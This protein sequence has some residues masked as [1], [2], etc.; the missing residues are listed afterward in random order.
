[1]VALFRTT[2]MSEES[3]KEEGSSVELVQVS[4]NNGQ[5]CDNEG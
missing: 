2:K 4:G 1:M 5:N 3:E